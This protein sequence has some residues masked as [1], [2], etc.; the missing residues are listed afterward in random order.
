[1]LTG[2]LVPSSGSIHVAGLALFSPMLAWFLRNA[3]REGSV[4]TDLAR[5]IPYLGQLLAN[6]VGFSTGQ[7]LFLIIAAPFAL[8][9][10]GMLPPASLSAGLFYL[11]SLVLAY[12]IATLIG[13]LIGLASFWT[14]ETGGVQS[15]YDFISSFFAGALVPLWFFPPVL[16]MIGSWLPFEAQ[17]FVPMQ[18]YHGQI[19]GAAILPAS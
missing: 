13:L 10:G 2:I 15:I 14:T 7:I 6:Q 9:L 16:R 19:S 5:P 8:V 12:A 1:M 17:G 18:I 11:V 4:A 3:V